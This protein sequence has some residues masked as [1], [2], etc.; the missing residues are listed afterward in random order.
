MIVIIFLFTFL[1]ILWFNT[2]VLV[3]YTHLLR[4]KWF[5]V[6]EYLLSKESD[7]TLTY[8]S[9]LLKKYNNFFVK[10]I[11]CPLCFNF[12]TIFIGKFIFNYDFIEIPTIYVSSLLIYLLFNKISL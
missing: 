8:H 9:F 5:K 10:L 11:T 7:F 1:L 6:D 12:W 4:L 3:E 2:E